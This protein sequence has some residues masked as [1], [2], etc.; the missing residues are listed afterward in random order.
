MSRMK[1][2]PLSFSYFTDLITERLTLAENA[3]QTGDEALNFFHLM[4][5]TINEN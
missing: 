3:F 4:K 2:I 1:V 5:L